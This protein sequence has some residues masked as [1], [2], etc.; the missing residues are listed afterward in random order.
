MNKTLYYYGNSNFFEKYN[1]EQL[2]MK[3]FNEQN[4][5][6]SNK[7][8][9]HTIMISCSNFVYVNIQLSFVRI[10]IADS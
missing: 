7:L 1:K 10:F 3:R 9:N 4:H 8:Y 6:K 2:V 5:I